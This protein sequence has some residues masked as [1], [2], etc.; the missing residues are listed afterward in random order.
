LAEGCVEKAS[1]AAA[2]GETTR[3][4]EQVEIVPAEALMDCRDVL[5]GFSA[6]K[7]TT[8]EVKD[9][10]VTPP[11]ADETRLPEQSAES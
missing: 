4:P 11:S 1:E 5:R 2:P 3:G 6:E 9:F 8:P 7:L 10:V